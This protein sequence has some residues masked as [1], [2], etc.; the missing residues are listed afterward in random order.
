MRREGDRA[1]GALVGLN[2]VVDAHVDL[3]VAALSEL[4]IAHLTLVGFDALVRPN[5]DL[6]A[7]GP[8]VSLRAVRTLKGQL[9]RVNQGVRL[10]MALGNELFA[11]AVGRANIR[12]F[13]SL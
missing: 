1:V 7:A 10:Q 9:A 12:P 8:R 5:V 4:V 6:Q 2:A 13:S 3:Q 11:T